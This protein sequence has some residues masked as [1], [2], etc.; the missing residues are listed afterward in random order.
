MTEK[1]KV[2]IIG[3]IGH[4]YR[5]VTDKDF[6][7]E[8]AIVKE[9]KVDVQLNIKGFDEERCQNREQRRREAMR[10]E[11]KDIGAKLPE[12]VKVTNLS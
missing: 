6:I 2:V 7:N 12:R 9:K 10:R 4:P 1:K 8:L 5:I 3:G 11:A